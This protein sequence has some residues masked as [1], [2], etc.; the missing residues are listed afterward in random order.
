MKASLGM[1]AR[2]FCMGAADVVPGV[3]GGTMAL[4]LGI[5]ERLVNAIR[6][7]DAAFVG[8]VARGRLREAAAHV[9]LAFLVPL[10]IGILCALL[11][12]TRVVSLPGLLR[13]HPEPVYA[14]FFG[15]IVGSVMVLLRGLNPLGW[16]GGVCVAI[17]I[18]LGFLVVTAVPF[19]TPEDAWFIFLAGALAICAMILPGI[20]GSFILLLLRKY[21]HVF[22][23]I[24]HFDFSVLVPFGLGALIGLMLFSRALVWMLAHHHRTT[25]STIVGLLIGS[26]WVVWPFQAQSFETIGGKER[27]VYSAPV[28]P[29][30]FGADEILAVALVVAGIAVVLVL[31]GL[32]VR[33]GSVGTR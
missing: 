2:G 16:R 32:S 21:E 27:L 10:A 18:L 14:L 6:A 1:L 5:Y 25:L 11:F 9:D 28:W 20:S 23:A 26:L 24:G 22:H 30:E 29:S 31:E 4:I 7:F 13:D 3:S 15:L 8:L 33:R 12:F 17:G 19:E